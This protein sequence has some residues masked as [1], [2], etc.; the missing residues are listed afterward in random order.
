M[1]TT[2]DTNVLLADFFSY[3]FS[4]D[5]GYVVIC[6]MKAPAKRDTFREQYFEW[7]AKSAEMLDYIEKV[8]FTH[9]VYFG[10][11]IMSVP[12]RIKENAIPQN[13]LW[14][15]LDTCRPDILEIPPQCVIESSPGRYQ[16]IWR[17]DRKVDPLLAEMYS[18]RIAYAYADNGADKSGHDLTQLLRVPGTFNYKYQL[19]NVPPIRLLVSTDTVLP[20]EV[21][22]KLPQPESIEIPDVA[23][24]DLADLPSHDMILY[25]HQDELQ[26]QGLA[27]TFARY[28]AEE[29]SEDWSGALWRLLLLC[30]EI[31]MTA[32][33]TFV[34]AHTSKCNKYERDGRPLS[35]L[36]REV[37]KAEAERK[38]VEIL[39]ADHRSLVMPSLITSAEAESL[40]P[41]I[42]DDY[43]GWASAATDAVPDFHEINCA[44]ILSALMATTLRLRTQQHQAIVPN[45]WILILGD[46]TL[47]RKTTTMNMA[48]DFIMDID[49][50]LI[51]ASDATAEGLLSALSTRPRMVSIFYR[52]EVTGFLDSINHKEYMR[53]MPEIMTKMYDVP[54][55]MPRRL[56]KETFIVSEPIFIFYGGGV[57]ERFYTLVEEHYYESGFM[58]RFLIMRGHGDIDRVVSVGPPKTTGLEKRNELLSTFRAF[59]EMYTNVQTSIELHDGQKMIQ[60]A[61]IDVV[62]TDEMW[63]RA[64]QMEKQLLD[65]A[66]N[67]P[68]A[69]KALPTFSRMFVSLL[70]LTML[71]AAARQEPTTALTIQAELRDLL[72]AAR[73]I[74][75]WGK[76]SVDLI[77]NS[78]VSA[79]E[80]KMMA[81][82]RT[83]E[84]MPG[85]MRGELMQ[86]HRL[87]ARAM[88][89]IQDTLIQRNMIEVHTKGKGKQFWPI[90]R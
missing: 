58:P 11:N 51:L 18:K 7:P 80:S 52:D 42:I 14:A 30:L 34:I 50:E 17:L 53:S 3:L 71:L 67:S 55:Y 37:V 13:L 86:R 63:T 59:H 23:M 57:P 49:R 65:S 41:T 35:H 24:P 33:E 29:P 25:R 74:E 56:R 61:E 16:A 54:K 60:T 31:G 78:G 43:V 8:M 10:V 26:K 87:N 48:M 6:T 20:P 15:D 73:Y 88:Q 66:F 83:V 62:F 77:R 85:I 84:R 21:F 82:Y 2:Q 64:G 45:L 38:S 89:L 81:L 28:Y 32:S 79:D 19:D 22:E 27:G 90:G 68:E 76:H 4:H 70:K 47:T 44:L 69:P 1:S 72:A 40:Q 5:E 12:R 39:L 46:T 36:W 75:R 9:N